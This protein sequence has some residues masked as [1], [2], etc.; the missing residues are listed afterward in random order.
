MYLW[1]SG[2]CNATHKSNKIFKLDLAVSDAETVKTVM[3]DYYKFDEIYTVYNNK[4]TF[5]GIAKA[6]YSQ[7]KNA[8]SQDL[9]VFYYAGHEV[10]K[11]AY[12][13]E[14]DIIEL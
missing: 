10:K 13:M 8:G 12:D 9:I 2:R 1:V 6:V 5:N 4:A 3:N 11:K 14:R 7:F